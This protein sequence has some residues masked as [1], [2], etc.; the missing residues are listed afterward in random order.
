MLNSRKFGRRK[1]PCWKGASKSKEQLEQAKL[2]LE[3]ARRSGDLQRM[4]ELQYGT[5]PELE[6]QLESANE[7][8]AAGAQEFS[9]AA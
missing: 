1:N 6:K 7:A 3:A 8:E 9:S 2:D 4:S 5:I